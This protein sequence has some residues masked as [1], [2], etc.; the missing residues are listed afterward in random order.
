[1]IKPE[2]IMKT[3]YLEPAIRNPHS[4]FIGKPAIRIPQSAIDYE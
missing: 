3:Q 2:L 4:A 1:M